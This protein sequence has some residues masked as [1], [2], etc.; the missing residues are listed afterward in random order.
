MPRIWLLFVAALLHGETAIRPITPA[1]IGIF[2]CG[3][4]RG[5]EK[6]KSP[7][8]RKAFDIAQEPDKTREKYGRTAIGQGAL[9]A[10]HLVEE[11]DHRGDIFPQL[12]NDFLPELDKA[13]S[14]LIGGLSE[15]GI[16]ESTIVLATR[17][18][19]E[20]NVN[21]A[22][23]TGPTLSRSS[24]PVEAYALAACGAPLTP[25]ACTFRT[26]PSKYLTSVQPGS[27][28]AALQGGRWK[29]ARLPDGVI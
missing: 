22:A 10:R 8:V 9:L 7:R 26:L 4:Q 13:F 16:L 29:T 21:V 12:A 19:P 14:S 25:M 3:L 17:R 24:S 11:G 2:P 28:S 27:T 18:A 6:M 1:I 5:T 15:R 23:I 20:I